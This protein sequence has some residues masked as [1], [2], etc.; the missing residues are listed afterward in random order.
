VRS[1]SGERTIRNGCDDVAILRTHLLIS[2]AAISLLNTHRLRDHRQ[3]IDDLWCGKAG[4]RCRVRLGLPWLASA[5]AAVIF[6]LI[7]AI[8]SNNSAVAQTMEPN[9]V[10]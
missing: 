3:G 2:D 8:T 1:A 6:W 4:I 10:Y 5:S 9:W 7:N